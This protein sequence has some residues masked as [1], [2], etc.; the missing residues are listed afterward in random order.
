MRLM[1]RIEGDRQMP[2]RPDYSTHMIYLV[3]LAGVAIR[4]FAAI[5]TYVINPDGMVYVQQAKA[6]Y[7]GDWPLLKSCMPF[8]SSYPFLIAA[9]YWLFPS[10]ID[11]ARLVSVFFG[12]LTLVPLYFLLRRFT[13]HGIAC[14]VVLLYA[15]M[16]VLVGGSADLIRDPICWFFLVSGLYFF[17]RQLENREAFQRRFFY[18]L[19]SYVLFLLACWARPETFI[20]LVFSCS[21]TFLYALFS[22]QKEYLLMA[23]S[24]LLLFGLFLAAGAMIFDPSFNSYSV[25]AS[26]KLF[27]SLEEY[28]NLRQQIE[29]LAQGLDRGALRSFLFKAKNLVWLIDLGL[30]VASTI[31]GIFY[32]YIP[33]FIFGLFGLPLRLRKDPRVVYL[34]FLIILGYILLFVHVLQFWY[35]ENRFLYIIIFPGCILAAFGIEK[36][37]RFI[38][39]RVNWKASVIIILISLYFLAFGLGK[40]IKKR[41]EDKVVYLQIAEYISELEKPGYRFIPVLTA[42]ASSLRLVPFYLNL[43][44][45]TGFCPLQTLRGITDNNALV[46]YV[47][48]NDVKYFLWDE[49]NWKRTQVDISRDDFRRIFNRLERWYHKDYGDIVLFSRGQVVGN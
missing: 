35:L 7:H 4:A 16:P 21:Y 34:F 44:L 32:P 48:D 10:W 45:P 9:T 33:F 22:K 15:F 19:S 2:Q 14:A 47:K 41:D 25:K 17:V 6:I 11:S 20:V 3:I 12:S 43:H 18:L 31:A 39:D 28:R 36:T 38:R 8:V 1:A 42:D 26:G 46:Q 24:S 29:V 5:N 40:N 27:A 30:L 23:V 13:D 49:K 37:T